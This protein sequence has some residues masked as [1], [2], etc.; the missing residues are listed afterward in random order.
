[1]TIVYRNA[2]VY[3]MDSDN[4]TAQAFA[5]DDG[6]FIAVGQAA[7]DLES[8]ADD[9]VDLAGATVI[10]G[11]MDVHNHHMIAGKM[12]LFE[13]NA[14]PALSIDELLDE[15]ATYVADKPA[16]AW[17]TGGS[18][19]TGILQDIVAS[20]TTEA[21]ARLD[22]VTGNRPTVLV[23]DSKHNRWANSAAL[24]LTG[25][26]RDT[27]NPE[28]GEILKAT[29]GEPNGILLEAAGVLVEKTKERL[30]PFALENLAQ[31]SARGVEILNSFGITGFQDAAASYQL[32][33]ALKKLDEE[34]RLK[35]W[36]TTS[37][38]VEEFIFGFEP[39]GDDVIFS[40]KDTASTHHR[41]NFIKIFLDGVPPAR[42]AA[43]LDN[44]LPEH[45]C[46]HLHNGY[47]TMKEGELEDWLLRTAKAGISA[48]I[49]CTGDRSVRA[50]LDAVE[51]VR[52]AGHHDTR[53]HVAHGQFVDE[54][55]IPRFA[56]LN[57]D[58]DISP[59]IWYPTVI[60]ESFK[61]VLAPERASQ[62]QPN[63]SLVDTGAIVAAGS[64]WPVSFSPNP[65]PAI[66]ALVTRQDPD[67]AM[68]GTLWPE[69]AVTPEE[70]I[71]IYTINVAQVMG[72]QDLT[73][74]IQTGKSA[75]FVTLSEDPFAVDLT[76]VPKITATQTWFAGESVFSA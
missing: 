31:A 29:D 24:K 14:D 13:L 63:R 41:P 57:V 51:Q 75:D 7:L 73:G 8:I 64:D 62:V 47:M 5:V 37:S 28:G 55:D 19:G 71:Q 39:L 17:I 6:K 27:E 43:F 66:Y 21:L 48:K 67:N 23:D 2:T 65:W 20:G 1:M 46:S 25:I 18:F 60:S 34:G 54:S 61:E 52:A 30:D 38:P 35:A 53:Y 36:V 72:I 16:D 22:E 59:P 32:Q 68:P 58:A 40:M 76:R 12:E 9:V 33:Q 3:T 44:Y 26:T 42:T 45:D 70:A 56:Q 49:H 74:S 11:L 50:V 10:P 69:Q 15:I 4:P